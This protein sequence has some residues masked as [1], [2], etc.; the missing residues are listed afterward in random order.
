MPSNIPKMVIFHK[1]PEQ[2]FEIKIEE[3]MLVKRIPE[4]LKK[5]RHDLATVHLFESLG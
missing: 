2:N 4:A 1:P 3:E 5:G